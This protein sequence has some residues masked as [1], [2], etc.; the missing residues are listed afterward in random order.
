MRRVG[1][2]AAQRQA[3]FKERLAFEEEQ[4]R[5]M[6]EGQRGA[7]WD[8]EHGAK[9]REKWQVDDPWA[10][11]GVSPDAPWSEIKKGYKQ[12]VKTSHPDAIG[13]GS[14]AAFKK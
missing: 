3:T 11:L 1:L 2:R 14:D 9:W 8:R 4:H 7:A 10:V 13:T 12:A 6:I 5:V